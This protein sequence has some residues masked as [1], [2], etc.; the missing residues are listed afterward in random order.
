MNHDY[1]HYL[2]FDLQK[3]IK[4]ISPVVFVAAIWPSG[5]FSE[6]LI[7]NAY[8]NLVCMVYLNPLGIA[9]KLE[10]RGKKNMVFPKS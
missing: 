4:K 1:F 2:R 9:I 6:P 5:C 7:W 3:Y 10:K 8:N